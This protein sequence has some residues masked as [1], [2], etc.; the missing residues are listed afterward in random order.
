MKTDIAKRWIEALRSGDYK[1]GR[2][3]LCSVVRVSWADFRRKENLRGD[4]A[5]TSIRCKLEQS[6]RVVLNMVC[7]IIDDYCICA[8]SSSRSPP[9]S[10]APSQVV[11]FYFA[12]LFASCHVIHLC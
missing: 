5:F 4:P 3:K 2:E 10:I 1:Q 7:G 6:Q 8:A 11:L 9:Q 12:S